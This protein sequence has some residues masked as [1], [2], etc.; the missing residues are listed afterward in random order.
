MYQFQQNLANQVH[1]Q[2]EAHSKSVDED[3]PEPLKVLPRGHGGVS[4]LWNTEK[5]QP[6]PLTDG[7]NRTVVVKMDD[8]VIVNIYMPCRG[9]YTNMEFQEYLDQLHEICKKFEECKLIIAGDFNVDP[10]KKSDAR[11]KSFTTLLSSNHLSEVKSIKDPTYKHEGVN[12]ESKIDF[13]LI[14]D[15]M[16][17]HMTH[18][19][20]KIHQDDPV[21]S[22]KHL[23]LVLTVFLPVTKQNKVCKPS[24]KI[25]VPRPIWNKCDREL[26]NLRLNQYLET[27][28]TPTCTKL[29]VEYL[30]TALTKAATEATP[31][32]K[33]KPKCAPWNPV[34]ATCLKETRTADAKWKK[35]IEEDQDPETLK[36]L[37]EERK[38]ARKKFRQAQR[39]QVANERQNNIMR[40]QQADEN[41]KNLFYSLIRKQRASTN[42]NTKELFVNNHLYV[43]DLLPAWEHHFTNLSTPAPN[44][45]FTYDRYNRACQN[46]NNIRLLHEIDDNQSSLPIPITKYEVRE[47]IN[48]LKKKKAKD[49]TGLMAEHLQTGIIP[50][51]GFLTP[52]L[53]K[54]IGTSDVP[55]EMT[56]GATHP[57][58]KKGK[59]KNISGN[60][61]GITICP[62]V[63][64]VMDTISL[65]HQKSSVYRD[66]DDL[67]FGFSNGRSG[68]HTAFILNE[69]I[70]ESL[71]NKTPLYAASL[72]VM[73]AFDV[74]RHES[75]LDKLHDKGLTP[76]W[77]RLKDA[78]YKSLTTRVIW[79]SR[80]SNPIKMQQGNCQGGL[81]SPDDYISYLD[82]NLQILDTSNLGFHI[83]S[84]GFVSP[85]CADDMLI[86]ARSMFELQVLLK[87]VATY[88][89]EEHYVI[90]PEKTVILPLNIQS[91][92]QIKHLEESMPWEINNAK[93]PVTKELVHVGIE[94]YL[95]SIDPTIDKRI[96]NG[97]QTLYGLFG[98]GMH[99]TNGLPVMTSVH[100]YQVYI[101]PRIIFGLEALVL[102]KT[103]FYNLEM[104]QRS[105]L[106]SLLG[107]PKRTAIPAL[108]I[109]TGLHPI[110]KQINRKQLIFLRSLISENGRLKD[111]VR[112]QYVMKKVNSKS[113]IV[114]IKKVLAQFSLPSLHDL[115]GDTPSKLTWK[116]EV[117]VAITRTTEKEIEEEASKM[118]TLQFLNPSLRSGKWHN[119]VSFIKNPREVARA[120]IKTQM[121]TG[122]YTFQCTRV[123]YKQATSETCQLCEEE[124]EDLVHA[125][126]RCSALSDVR[127]KY[128]PAIINSIPLVYSHRTMVMND[129]HLLTQLIMDSTH[130]RISEL[131]PLQL[132]DQETHERLTRNFCFAIH[133]QRSN[134]ITIV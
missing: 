62:I 30:T 116:E 53:D 70:A 9:A 5:H 7:N 55:D 33:P 77:W 85:T 35:S 78:V 73:K 64:K 119:V 58:Q 117:K 54:I 36:Q 98:S 67:Q 132:G 34:I 52:V 129:E 92:Q 41:D 79:D 122:T 125:L 16:K 18:A 80:L 72:D 60:Y 83:G 76:T 71:D 126:L 31:H 111:L 93:L 12:H 59:P 115:L 109:I 108:Y 134:L 3:N 56:E 26:Y 105:I 100:L 24:K 90:H 23:P 32:T 19:E 44:N 123:R 114:H 106:K 124:S 22:S 133:L 6:V 45:N 99:G 89:N 81:A 15:N 102:K 128:L 25:H 95:T 50:V 10:Y 63:T 112:R 121:L 2:Y 118:N 88:A 17:N 21:N 68:V 113:W 37:G 65:R 48:S 82:D 101:I 74:V 120:A 96:A 91:E 39:I 1:K 27:D 104:L 97:R 29:A 43:G 86:L 110:E 38:Q 103:H 14:N 69:C 49:S 94:R 40:L 131:I 66:P 84:M 11:V 87:L 47:A 127:Q 130:P 107:V 28:V 13:I 8:I 57:I 46:I 20:Y 4:T 51:T 61:R 42:T 75:L